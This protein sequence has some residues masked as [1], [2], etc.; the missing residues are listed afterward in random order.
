[1][2][3]T[4]LGEL[5]TEGLSDRNILVENRNSLVKPKPSV[6]HGTAIVHTK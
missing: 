3:E 6:V 4:N 2:T 1:M 5:R